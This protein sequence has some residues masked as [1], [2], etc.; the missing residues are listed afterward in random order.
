[1]QDLKTI[2]L[3]ILDTL[4]YTDDKNAF[5]DEFINVIVIQALSDLVIHLSDEKQEQMRKEC[6]AAGSDPQRINQIFKSYFTSEQIADSVETEV[7]NILTECVKQV[8]PVLNENQRQ[9]LIALS[10]DLQVSNTV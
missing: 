7:K 5:V 9:E 1:M 6:S 8:N 3:K 10:K 4:G 2:I